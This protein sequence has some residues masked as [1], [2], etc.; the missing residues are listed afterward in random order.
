MIDLRILIPAGAAWLA[1]V[2][3]LPFPA[4]ILPI[5]IGAWV[6]T[7]VMLALA[8]ARGRRLLV[9][10]AVAFAAIALVAT[11]AFAHSDSRHPP[12]LLAGNPRLAA[13]TIVTTETVTRNSKHFRAT[14][15]S[16]GDRAVAVPVVVFDGA[17][18]R[19]TEIGSTLALSG[20]MKPTAP[21]EEQSFL[22]FADGPAHLVAK[23]P[24]YLAWA[25]G[26]RSG[27]A[28]AATSLPGDGG[29]LL[30]GLA[31]G[32]TVA[33]SPSLS[34]DLKT[35]SLSHLT[36]VSGANC[37]VVIGLILLAGRAAGLRRS[38]RV[39]AA[40]VVLVGFVVLVTPEP[41]V[42]RAAVMAA[43]VLL[44]LARG[45]PIGGVP[46]IGVAIIILLTVDPWLARDYGFA[47]SALATVGLVVLSGPLARL[48][49]RWMP[50]WIA[51]VVAV[52]LAAQLAC[53]PVLIFLN[54]TV[55]VY[56]VIANTLAEPASP[57][58][59]VVGLA[60]CLTLAVFPPLGHVLAAVAWVPS[61]WIAAV[62]RFFASLPGARLPWPGG[63]VGVLVLACITVLVLVLVLAP[64]RAGARRAIGFVL[65]VV[66][67]GL[68][69]I[70]GV[71]NIVQQINRPP[72]WQIADCDIG[73]GDAMIV[74]S[75]GKVAL[76][77]T[78][79]SP[80]LLKTCLDTLGI[81]RIDLL[82]LSHYDLDHVA[83]TPV[84]DH[85]V[86]RAIVGPS[87]GQPRDAEIIRG[88]LAGGTRVDRVSRG[89]T[90]RLGDLRWSVIW[91][92]AQLDG[93]QPGNDACVTVL[94]EPVGRCEDGCLSSLFVG[95]LGERPQDLV[96]EANPALPRVDVIEV[97][98][99]GS[100]DQSP[101]F[102][103]RVSATVGLIGVGL[104]NRY[105]HPTQRLFDILASVG[106]T[107]ERTD[108]QGLVL[109]KPGGR[110][111]TVA[112]W[113]EHPDAGG[114]G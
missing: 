43:L 112:V 7:G 30:P 89:I 101:E 103:R 25:N 82:V 74:R 48:L 58:A 23:P 26:L 5:A 86:D 76:M 6:V 97:A 44:A 99:H 62:A 35:S 100:A 107:A 78:G 110:A 114:P 51:T 47:L 73:Q 90:G 108:L 91:P 72:D 67:V 94:F 49:A 46:V 54:P 92:L 93:I 18:K 36:A 77:D 104:H 105:G 11:S 55:P 111:G 87:S 21:D 24:W 29:S 12:F 57:V 42:L 109:V 37:A 65:A 2:L 8:L 79:P 64:L 80:A 15:T 83:G 3:F 32:D 75:A 106:T 45:R 68:V 69:T 85:M 52:P 81:T 1:A 22:V 59:T 16:V 38:H 61:A 31:I 88:L 66:V 17:P 98:H 113:S 28:W 19:R 10:I 34:D 14:L 39:I 60:A 102:Y 96:L 41:S 71:S 40:I 56:G 84:V 70:T 63:I 20:S 4:G 33:V 27:L 95:D 50:G 13:A 53:Q 9:T